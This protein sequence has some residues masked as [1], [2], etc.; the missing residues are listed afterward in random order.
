MQRFHVR[1]KRKLNQ[2]LSDGITTKATDDC[3]NI[4][5]N[6]DK[7]SEKGRRTKPN[8]IL[9]EAGSPVELQNYHSNG[10]KPAESI[11]SLPSLRANYAPR[12]IRVLLPAAMARN[13]VPW[14]ISSANESYKFPS[15][16][17]RSAV[18][19]ARAYKFLQAR[20]PR[21]SCARTLRSTC[22]RMNEAEL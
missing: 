1:C 3:S 19:R 13:N 4:N 20:K 10:H 21:P 2:S 9:G 22:I 12:Q 15:A 11:V 18:P 6:E 16:D 5:C 14:C 7:G 17:F 8:S